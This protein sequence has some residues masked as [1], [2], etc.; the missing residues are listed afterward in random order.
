M[1]TAGSESVHPIGD[2]LKYSGLTKREYFAAMA[3]QTIK[4][5]N[6]TP[7]EMAENAVKIAD[8]LI[9]ELNNKQ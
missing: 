6:Y 7:E 2:G 4:F 9:E 5:K 3:L 1:R 8:A